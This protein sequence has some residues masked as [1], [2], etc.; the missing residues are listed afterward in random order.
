MELLVEVV[1]PKICSLCN[2]VFEGKQ[3]YENHKSEIHRKGKHVCE[4]CNKRYTIKSNL[5]TH[6]KNDH[7]SDKQRPKC[8]S[9]ELSLKGVQSLS[10]HIKLIHGEKIFS[11][12]QCEEKFSLKKVFL[13]DTM[14]G[15]I[16]SQETFLV[17]SV[18]KNFM[19]S[20]M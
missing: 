9:C 18:T 10:R 14:G 11:C 3:E 19:I 20:L 15:N 13:I 6:I 5:S 4:F 17:H 2:I 16:Q 12:D 1:A 8:P 7:R